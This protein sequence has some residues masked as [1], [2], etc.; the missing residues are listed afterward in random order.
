MALQRF[1]VM[2]DFDM[3]NN[4]Q[5]IAIGHLS[6][7]GDLKNKNAYLPTHSKKYESRYSKHIIF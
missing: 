5:R 3:Q 6:D 4:P 2:E 7:S 1:H